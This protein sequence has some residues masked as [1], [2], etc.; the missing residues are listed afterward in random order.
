[1]SK[2]SELIFLYLDGEA[3]PDEQQE[4]F[5]ALSRSEDL[6][7]EFQQA[8]QLYRAMDS[9]RLATTSAPEEVK[10][11]VF[12]AIGLTPVPSVARRA[13]PFASA[14]I[15]ALG[16][17]V[18]IWLSAT[19]APLQPLSRI[20]SATPIDVT[21]PAA[22]VAQHRPPVAVPVATP[23]GTSV[24]PSTSAASPIEPAYEQPP[25][26]NE[27]EFVFERPTTP[28]IAALPLVRTAAWH[29]G[30]VS[31]PITHITRSQQPP[32][33]AQFSY[34][35]SLL[36]TSGPASSPQNFSIAALY[37]FDDNHRVGL[38][39]RRAPYTLN[40]AGPRSTLTTAILSSVAVAY[41]FRQ[42]DVR[43]LGSMPFVQPT[44]GLSQ[45]GPVVTMSAGLSFP[46]SNSLQ[47]D[48]GFDG[49][50]LVYSGQVAS[51]LGVLLGINVGLPIR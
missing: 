18:Y 39:F 22:M 5:E 32:F 21:A 28:V 49:S 29:I 17:G 44:V 40:I 33:S 50:A 30:M 26:L 2:Q 4:L 36:A 38:E 16:I 10:G 3:T 34:R 15:A 6:Q 8:L 31:V 35:G 7:R 37:S 9:E 11:A 42:P 23:S 46:I 24:T 47:L 43:I 14:C 25:T 1:M 13:I 48:V 20:T 19:R 27:D 12:A 51:N 41:S 45:L